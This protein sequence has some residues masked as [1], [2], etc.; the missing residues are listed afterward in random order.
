VSRT[1]GGFFALEC[2][3]KEAVSQ[4]P[5]VIASDH[6]EHGPDESGLRR[7]APRNDIMTQ[8]RKLY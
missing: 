5:F 4:P 1:L 3:A 8:P 6:R 7:F 2:K